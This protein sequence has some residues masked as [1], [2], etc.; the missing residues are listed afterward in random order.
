[1]MWTL[2]L[3]K[4][5]HNAIG[6]DRDDDVFDALRKLKIAV[7]L[8]VPTARELIAIDVY[9]DNEQASDADIDVF[10]ALRDLRA[11]VGLGGNI[12]SCGGPAATIS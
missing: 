12:T 8:V 9:P 6:G 10:D 4:P 2:H 7:G 3:H 1:M 5:N 11:A